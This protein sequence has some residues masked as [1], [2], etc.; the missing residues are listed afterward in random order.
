MI[1]T[2]VICEFCF[3]KKTCVFKRSNT[4]DTFILKDVKTKHFIHLL[5]LRAEFRHLHTIIAQHFRIS[6]Q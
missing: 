6:I 4:I 3:S 2:D 1:N 5:Y